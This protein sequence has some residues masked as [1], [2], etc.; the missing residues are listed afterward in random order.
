MPDPR[1][2]GRLTAVADGMFVDL[3]QAKKIVGRIS[4]CKATFPLS[5]DGIKK[6]QEFVTRLSV[7]AKSADS[8][9]EMTVLSMFRVRAE[10]QIDDLCLCPFSAIAYDSHN[11]EEV[12][13]PEVIAKG[14]SSAVDWFAKI[15]KLVEKP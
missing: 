11:P 13:S 6:A 7:S 1:S 4:V 9:K 12:D 15:L 2:V 10:V 3:K 14:L 5:I 8:E